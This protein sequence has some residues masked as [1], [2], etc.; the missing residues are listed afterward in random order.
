MNVTSTHFK[1]MYCLKRNIY[2][3]A[4]LTDILNISESKMKR[5]LKDLEH[6]FDVANIESIHNKITKNPK[7]IDRLRR[8]QNFTPEE[9][10]MYIILKLLKLDTINL[11]KISEKIGFSRRTLANDLNDLKEILEKFNLE[12]RNLTRYG[13]VLEGR[14][15]DKRDF[16]KLYLIKIFLEQKYLPK[17][18][19]KFFT[20]FYKIKDSHKL[21]SLIKNIFKLTDLPDNTFVFLNMECITYISIIRKP[22]EDLTTDTI[23]ENN[24]SDILKNLRE[25]L[26]ETNLYSDFDIY[27]LTDFAIKKFKSELLQMYPEKAKEAVQLLKYIETKLNVNIPITKEL[28][29]RILLITIVMDYKKS[30]NINEFYI[31]NNSI[32]ESYLTPY[33]IIANLLKKFFHQLDS[34]DLANLTMTLLNVVYLDMKK[35][36]ENLKNIAVVFNILHKNLVIDL[37]EDLGLKKDDNQYHLVSAFELKEFLDK[38]NPKIILTFEDL[39]FS[40]Y[41][42][43]D[44]L[45][46]FNFPITKYDKLKLKPLIEKV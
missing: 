6:L 12:I 21:Y 25:F 32:G 22:F 39:D 43:D 19:D 5:Y 41:N 40:K 13:V 14:E 29:N 38:N 35:K 18:F 27:I 15:R 11:S 26:K 4:E 3:I 24:N 7:I 37:C 23:L 28:L 10:Q 30:F 46:E 36:V 8:K 31:F 45:I 2:S 17:M 16:F 33:K 44:K 34:F 1:I 9:R 42:I 20:E